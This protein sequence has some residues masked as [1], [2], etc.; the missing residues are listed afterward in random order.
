LVTYVFGDIHGCFKTARALYDSLEFD[1][2]RD[3]LWL[4][5]DLVNRGPRSLEVL[6]WAKKLSEKLGPRFVTVLGNHDLHLLALDAGRGRDQHRVTLSAV[7]EAPDRRELL[8]WL[9]CRPLVYREGT[10]DGSYLLVHAGLHPRWKP[11]K[12]ERKAR[13]LEEHLS[14][15]KS[16][17]KLLDSNRDEGL[18]RDLAVFTGIRTCTRDGRL[19]DYTGAPEGAPKGCLPWFEIDERKSRKVTIVAGHWAA[20]GLRLEKTFLGLDSGCVYGGRL[21]AVRLEDRRVFTKAN[22]D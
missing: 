1:R 9:R 15:R 20:L 22:R 10:R 5:G 12:A 18:A 19:C 3:R 17:R 13:R 6:R 16:L 4:V 21:S 11:G 7:L 14:S 2:R 8:D